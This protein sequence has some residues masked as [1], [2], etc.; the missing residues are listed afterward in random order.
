MTINFGRVVVGGVVAGI[1]IDTYQAVMNDVIMA[2]QWAGIMKSLCLP[3]FSPT[4]VIWFNIVGAAIRPRF[5]SDPRTALIAA[6]LTWLKAKAVVVAY[7]I[8]SGIYLQPI[9]PVLAAQVPEIAIATLAG[10]CLYRE[11][12]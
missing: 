11:A 3:Q 6:A 4:A 7:P 12:D 8:I 9:G 10:A 1:M 5:G 2:P